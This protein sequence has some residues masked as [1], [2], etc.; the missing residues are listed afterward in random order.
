MAASCTERRREPRWSKSGP[1][2][3]LLE[4]GATVVGELLDVSA[5]GFRAQHAEQALCSGQEL[6]FEHATAKGR[7]RVMWNRIAE[8]YVESG[9]LLI[10]E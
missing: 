8:G 7:A 4:D 10:H 2:N 6:G 3:L 5:G 9:F 1:V